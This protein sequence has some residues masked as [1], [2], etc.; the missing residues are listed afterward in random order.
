MGL[1]GGDFRWF[2]HSEC[3][4][5]NHFELL[6]THDFGFAEAFALVKELGFNQDLY[7]FAIQP[8]QIAVNQPIS[9]RLQNKIPILTNALLNHM[10]QL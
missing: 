3:Q 6:S 8:V 9:N 10:N 1:T 5:T 2:N 4:L 7:F